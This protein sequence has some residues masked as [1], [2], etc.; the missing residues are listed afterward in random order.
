MRRRGPGVATWTL[1]AALTGVALLGGTLV[2]LL[3]SIHSLNQ[4]TRL[5]LE[6]QRTVAA[7]FE[8]EES[9]LDVVAAER[10]YVATGNARFLTGFAALLRK[11][12]AASASVASH[13]SPRERAQFRALHVSVT[14][15][16][17]W[18]VP[19]V[20]LAR[21]VRAAAI[22][23]E[24]TGVGIARVAAMTARAEALLASERDLE[25]SRAARAEHLERRLL[26][27]SGI[28]L[29]AA[30]LDALGFVFFL[31]KFV[32]RPIQGLLAA[33][34]R[35]RSGDPSVRL[36]PSG[37]AEIRE[38]E[39]GFNAMAAALADDRRTLELAEMQLVARS[40]E[41]ESAVAEL[42]VEK[43]TAEQLYSL[44]GRLAAESDLSAAAQ[45]VVDRMAGVGAA[46][47]AVLYATDMGDDARWHLLASRGIGAELLP[48]TIQPGEPPDSVLGPAHELHVPLLKGTRALGVV[49]LARQRPGP[50][51]KGERELLGH[52]ADQ[53]ALEL[54][55]LL[56]YSQAVR[57][58]LLNKTLIES[59]RDGIRLIDLEGT[60]LAQNTRMDD[61]LVRAA[62]SATE[63]SFWEQAAVVGP[64][65]K[66]PATFAAVTAE[67]RADPEAE[68][69]F[70][71]E[72]A[73]TGQVL[74]R[75]IGPVRDAAGRQVARI[76]I[77]R[78]VTAERQAQRSRDDFV[79]SVTHEL[80]TPLTSISG[81][82]EL[83]R[84]DEAGALS[85]E[86]QRFLEVVDR[87]ATRLLRLVN[88]LLFIGR[89][90]SGVLDLEAGPTDL[91][92][93]VVDA[94]AAARPAAEEKGVSISLEGG[95]LPEIVADGGRIAQLV[96]NLLSNGI[97]F[98]PRGGRVSVQ[99]ESD[100][101]IVTLLVSDTGVGVT[102]DEKQHLFDRFFRASSAI[103]EAVPGTGL[104]LAISKAIVDAHGGA[105]T[106]EDT[107]GGGTTFRLELPVGAR[108]TVAA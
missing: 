67:L 69:V 34:S 83:L 61:L 95:L 10:G 94:V 84:D 53:S 59:S 30:L 60:I 79:A 38:L 37:L 72:L 66:D 90:D 13:L 75:F 9:T 43:E 104:G 23:L 11:H 92:S 68:L 100:G 6:T 101:E 96:D 4:A 56:A 12:D 2:L 27:V 46:D 44:A 15:V 22:A 55:T 8:T 35:V 85:E 58:G 82:L 18:A 78:D 41:L 108:A 106:V 51:G 102:D 3:L 1:A 19:Q 28:G 21:R 76:V 62:G 107:P 49:A 24:A 71:Y 7:A 70:E 105:I 48:E 16:I 39:L 91:R 29:G 87:N 26:L 47:V 54:S 42:T 31:R 52:M 64:L 98:T 74:S 36:D 88:D 63:G 17:A 103:V 81:Y 73:P 99:A 86:Q 33:Q 89:L 25:V 97:K 40:S 80:R 20:E 77:L 45:V 14:R 57:V 5:S 50:F 32:A 65:T 93:I